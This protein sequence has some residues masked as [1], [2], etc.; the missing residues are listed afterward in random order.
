MNNIKKILNFKN[1][2]NQDIFVSIK[3][4]DVKSI[5]NYID[6]GYDLNKQNNAGNTIL[7]YATIYNNIE[8]VKL[9]LNAGADI[10]KQD[11]YNETP[12]ILAA[13]KNNIEII[14]LLL[15]T[16]A[17]MDK[18]NN[19]DETAL[20]I[21][22][23]YNNREVIELLLDYGADEF[24]LD[25]ENK[26]FYEHLNDENKQYFMQNYPTSVYNAIYHKYKK[27]FTEF[28]KDYNIK[29]N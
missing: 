9:L 20:I 3:N 4:N 2:K 8:I 17:D 7:I 14:K 26:S 13:Y 10:N 24:I 25:Y 12:L 15:S 29:N 1:F 22:A 11:K 5:K 6:S 16:G 23:I 28:V 18:Q 27:S 19:D 21:A